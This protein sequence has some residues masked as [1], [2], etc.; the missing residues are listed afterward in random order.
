MTT[1][2]RRPLALL[3]ALAVGLVMAVPVAAATP[4]VRASDAAAPGGRFI[5]AWRDDAPNHLAI[6]GVRRTE[7]SRRGQRSLVVARAGEAGKV[8]AALRADPRVLLVTPDAV[9]KESAWPA[10]GDPSDTFFADQEDLEQIRVP[11]VWPTTIGDPGLV[12][13]VLDSGVDLDHPDLAGVT[14][15]APRNEIWNNTDIADDNG[16]G[17][18]VTGTILART[19][20][21][22]GIAGIAPGASLMP[23]KVLDETGSGYFSDVLDGMDWARTHGADVVNLSLG[24]ILEPAQVALIQ[25][26][27]TA[28]RAA[29]LLVVAA[30]GNSGSAIMEYP[31]GL[32]GVVSVAAVDQSDLQAEFS[33][34]N[35]GVDI[36]APGVDILST[37]AG[38][39]EEESGT[40]MA[41]PHVAG[42]AALIWSARP[43]LSVAELEAVLRASAAD[44]GDP[45]RDNVYGSGRVDAEAALA[46]AVPS[47]L[48]DL[49]PAPGFT[50]PLTITFS[51]PATPRKQASRSVD[52]AWTT[53]HAVIDGIVLRLSWRIVGGQCPDPEFVSYDD[54]VLL[55]FTSP[56]H[57]T[58]LAVGILLSMGRAGDRRGRPVGRDRE[59]AGLDRR[60]DPAQDQDPDAGVRRDPRLDEGVVKVVFTEPVKGVS[61]STLRLKNLR[62]WPVGPREGHLR[63]GEAHRDHRPGEVHVPRTSIHRRRP[64]RHQGSVGQPARAGQLELQDPT[65]IGTAW[66]E[67]R[68]PRSSGTIV[69]VRWLGRPISTP[70]RTSTLAGASISPRSRRYAPSAAAAAPVAGSSTAPPTGNGSLA[71]NRSGASR[72]MS[73]TVV[74][75]ASSISAL[76]ASNGYSRRA[77]RPRSRAARMRCLTPAKA[78]AGGRSGSSSSARQP[79]SSSAPVS[80]HG[81][82]SR[83]QGVT[84]VNVARI[85]PSSSVATLT[86]TGPPFVSKAI[87][88]GPPTSAGGP[89]RPRSARATPLAMVAWPQNWTSASGLK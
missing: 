6:A 41:S 70:W 60:Y 46:E 75:S 49:E 33:T 27:F 89:A 47:P 88:S 76:S 55:D 86:G 87:A 56:I 52:V 42:V 24:G 26:T 19:D 36:S 4:P 3:L 83:T 51:S 80:S 67:T 23:I 63:Q 1:L 37:T 7:P 31:A 15:V 62:T 59:R 30:S 43:S 12:I 14:V 39:Y 20:N 13:A 34:F 82:G 29:G 48:P 68:T 57:E 38:D 18:H 58:G 16:H 73:W 40:S 79:S 21:G 84:D 25:P 50:D 32:N 66:P 78:T 77:S 11:E 9:V 28:A 81:S 22:T 71:R 2:P 5:V 53:S 61:G 44:L 72:Q 10:D 85:R 65:L 17:T 64:A 54:V 45:G 8:G 35:R 69:I 74:N